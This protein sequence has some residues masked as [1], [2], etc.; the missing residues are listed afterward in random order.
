M[1]I[2][3]YGTSMCDD[4]EIACNILEAYGVPYQ[5]HNVDFM[6]PDDLMVLVNERAPN[7]KRVPIIF[8]DGRKIELNELNDFFRNKDPLAKGLDSGHLH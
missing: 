8:I 5:F 6:S 3:V 4:C 1:I 2:E 7:T